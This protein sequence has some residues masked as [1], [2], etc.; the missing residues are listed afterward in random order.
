MLRLKN[1]NKATESRSTKEVSDERVESSAGSKV[2]D[3]LHML[4]DGGQDSIATDSWTGR[5]RSA[6]YTRIQLKELNT[7]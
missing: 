1:G 2:E 3:R 5:T 7:K 6:R 4:I